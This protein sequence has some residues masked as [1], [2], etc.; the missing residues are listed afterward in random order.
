MRKDLLFIVFALLS[1]HSFCQISFEKGYYIDYSDNK[2]DCLIKN[3]DWKNNPS[4]FEYKLSEDSEI[5]TLDASSA[6]EFGID[7]NSK[8]VRALVNIER[9]DPNFVSSLT[10]SSQP[11]FNKEELFL[12]V[13]IQGKAN[14][15]T[16]S[17]DNITKYFYSVDNS[18]IEQLVFIRYN[19][20]S[21]IIKTNQYYKQQLWLNLKCDGILMNHVNK[22]DYK[23][24]DLINFFIKYNECNQSEIINYQ[25]KQKRGEF[26]VT[27]R[28]RLNNS[29]LTI[30]QEYV[31]YN[32]PS[33]LD[34]NFDS[35]INFGFGIE[36][37]FILP[38]NKSKWAILIEPTYNSFQNEKTYE[39]TRN[40]LP[41]LLVT[42]VID[43]KSIELPIGVRHYLFLS[44]ESKI[45]I[46]L[47]FTA[48]FSLNS[49]LDYTRADGSKHGSIEI[50]SINNNFT[51]GIGYKYDNKYSIEIRNHFNR[52]ILN[53]NA[54]HTSNYN[55]LS[56]ILGY[57][58]F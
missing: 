57:T 2:V 17:A 5:N 36:S 18:A 43:Y 24:N 49:K 50:N 8:Y 39:I 22:V 55:T 1:W 3:L 46:N 4:E 37:E 32:N 13:L 30:K 45:F 52:D 31:Y 54:L 25:A 56:L 35:K 21:N 6:K 15:Y 44:D 12:K 48:D 19:A 51:L 58:I 20:S 11:V 9:S 41:N 53:M 26:N 40:F 42:A 10:E 28:P 47:L 34:V 16:Y 14:L 7:N 23:K 27:L 33:S 29:S 38:F